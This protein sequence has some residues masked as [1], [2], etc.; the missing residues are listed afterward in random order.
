MSVLEQDVSACLSPMFAGTRATLDGDAQALLATW[1]TKT[2]YLIDVATTP[3]I[4]RGYPQQLQIA[5]RPPEGTIVWI[6]AYKQP[7]RAAAA[8]KRAYRFPV[9]GANHPA[10]PNAY[11]ITFTVTRVIFQVVG[12]F[13]AGAATLRD[14]RDG[15]APA[16]LRIWPPEAQS[17]AWP[18]P[19]VFNDESIELLVN[20]INDGTKPAA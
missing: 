7:R 11:A 13:S 12:H 8:W 14:G 18:P 15:L 9:R 2:A 17:I 6:S 4:P 20:S 3:V 19:F 16:L 10:E 5:R 1:A